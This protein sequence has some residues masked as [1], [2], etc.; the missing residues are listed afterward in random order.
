MESLV[1]T[2]P[3]TSFW[4]GKRVFL[5]GHTG[6]K[7]TWARLWLG[8]LGAEVTG[9]SLAPETQPCLHD[10]VGEAGLAAQT[11]GDIRDGS[12]LSEALSASN[13]QIIIHMAAQP[14]VRRSYA[15]PVET[16]DVNVMG[17]IRLL[18]AARS[19]ERLKAVLVDTTD[20]VYSNDES[21]RHFVETDPLGGHDPYSGSKA[22]AEI[23]TASYRD[24][25]YQPKRVRLATAR[26]GNVI[27]GGDF[28]EDRLVPDIVRAAAAGR[29]LSIRNPMATRPWQH[30]L[31]CLSG[32]FDYAQA[33]Y[34]ETTDVGSLNFGPPPSELQIPVQ[35]VA[36]AIQRAMNLP[37]LWHD[38]SAGQPREMQSLGLDPALAE[39]TLAWRP[40]FSQ[41]EAIDWTAR[42]YDAWRRNTDA[43]KLT[44]GQIDAY[45]KD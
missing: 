26:G 15:E 23:A 21:G 36:A 2:G 28:S 42:W 41:E 44:L 31:D 39:K 12:R 22:A 43:R 14:L 29:T 17:T 8:R 18:E 11:I 33:L 25:F 27:G 10:L 35:D 20:K 3:H 6:F 24:S 37:Q 4:A 38:N 32:Y 34:D 7:G 16:F 19:L 5:T 45:T 40:R 9:Y 30:V 1:M 13:P